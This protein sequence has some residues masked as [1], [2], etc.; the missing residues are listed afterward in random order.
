MVIAGVQLGAGIRQEERNLTLDCW[1]RH[2]GVALV[3]EGENISY[4]E[5]SRRVQQRSKELG[6]L[7]RVVLIETAN[8]PEPLITY[9]ACVS[10]GHVALLVGA[11]DPLHAG[12]SEIET[13]YRPDTTMRRNVIGSWDLTSHRQ[14]P[15]G[16][17]NSELSVL[18]STSGS[19]GSPKMVKL[20]YDNL[21]SNA[22][23][24]SQYLSLNTHDVAATLLPWSYC[25]GLS[26]INSHL[27]SG[28]K[29]VLTDLSVADS[30]FW[31]LAVNTK[32]TNISGVPYSFQVMEEKG[33]KPSQ[34]PSLRLITQAGGR[35]EPNAVVRFSELCRESGCDFYVMYGQSE[36][37]ARIAYLEP[38]LALTHADCIG[39]PIPGGNLW[40]E[41]VSD[42]PVGSSELVYSGPNV[43]IGYAFDRGDLALGRQSTV[44]HTGDLAELTDNG[45]FRIT[46]RMNRIA[47]PFGLRVDLDRLERILSNS[48]DEIA[49]IEAPYGLAVVASSRNHNPEQ[50]A[51]DLEALARNVESATG[52]PLSAIRAV[53]VRS[54]PRLNNGK[55]DYAKITELNPISEILAEH[56]PRPTPKEQGDAGEILAR[57]LRKSHV[58]NE[59]SFVSLAGDSM[60]YV[61]VSAAL[62]D[63]FG[64]LP[65]RWQRLTVSELNKL[66]RAPTRPFLT[67]TRLDVMA[68]LRTIAMILIA[69]SHIGTFDIRGG[70]HLLLALAGFSLAKFH[71][72]DAS[73]HLRT[74]RIATSAG[75]IVLISLLWL[76]PLVIL[77]NSYGPSVMFGIN[78]FGPDG[79]APEWRYWFLEAL[80]YTIAVTAALLFLPSV[81]RLERRWPFALPLFLMVVASIISFLFAAPEGPG[82]MYTPL[83]AGWLF[84]AGWA[85]QRAPDTA[86][87]L[88]VLVAVL[89][90]GY[91]FFNRPDRV[92]IVVVGLALAAFLMW[93]PVPKVAAAAATRVAGASLVIYVSHYQIY[94]L[95][96]DYKWVALVVSLVSGV[97]MWTFLEMLLR[98][99][100]LKRDRLSKLNLSGFNGFH[101]AFSVRRETSHS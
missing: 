52:L 19:T 101:A 39:R 20:S 82:T 21:E 83:V 87:R 25:Y 84:A 6:A 70:A 8:H 16:E 37:T 99:I 80:I 71:L 5:L 15:L 43:M 27:A 59:D 38:E 12:Y 41:P 94:P 34:I 28:A 65:S 47:K 66:E 73:R 60:S 58:S 92:A 77:S 4:P 55:I 31:D 86:R 57:I 45:L 98:R 61:A 88:L 30:C 22:Q 29:V 40:L 26:V 35:M 63:R 7:R 49:C 50:A 89:G 74:Q 97:A 100:S 13:E 67:R 64:D 72:T 46:G 93:V 1:S 10:G 81:D 95:F 33:F 32:I 53:S 2:T 48:C 56:P 78:F 14:V 11:T 90:V 54:I 62:Q 42:G 79:G 75:R 18:L 51:T 24:I 96:G 3:F 36:A 17:L 85:L 23:A 76:V 68:L 91:F 44:L 69:G 9:L